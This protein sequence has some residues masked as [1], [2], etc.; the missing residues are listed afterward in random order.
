MHLYKVLSCLGY[1]WV[2]IV[3]ISLDSIIVEKLSR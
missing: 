1:V 3:G 2:N